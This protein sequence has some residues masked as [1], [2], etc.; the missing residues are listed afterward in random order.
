MKSKIPIL[1]ILL[2][3]A[4]CVE[5]PVEYSYGIVSVREM[6]KYV[7]GGYQLVDIKFGE[8]SRHV[9]VVGQNSITHYPDCKYC[10]KEQDL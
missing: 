9:Y 4:S 10:I 6:T 1:F 2:S 8:D 7:S 5:R 3:L